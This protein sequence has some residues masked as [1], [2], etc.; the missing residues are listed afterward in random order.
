MM[1]SWNC[2]PARDMLLIMTPWAARVRLCAFGSGGR[3]PG[4]CC[5]LTLLLALAAP[6]AQAYFYSS[7]ELLD[8]GPPGQAETTPEDFQPYTI[9]IL[10]ELRQPPQELDLFIQEL[11]ADE[12]WEDWQRFQAST[13]TVIPVASAQLYIIYS[14][15]Y[16]R[17]KRPKVQ[18]REHLPKEPKVVRRQIWVREGANVG[19]LQRGETKRGRVA[20]KPLSWLFE[21]EG[22]FSGREWTWDNFIPRLLTITGLVFGLLM[23]VEFL[24]LLAALGIR[25]LRGRDQREARQ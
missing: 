11:I 18:M 7:A 17:S 9:P 12:N 25:T 13:A 2:R 8:S 3:R 22:I 15:E 19:L 1:P 16:A 10:D 21:D 6:S 23:I 14:E 5:L 4:V 24:H 20:W